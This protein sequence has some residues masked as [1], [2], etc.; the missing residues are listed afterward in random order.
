M[1]RF[2]LPE[3]W[4][5]YRSSRGG[6]YQVDTIHLRNVRQ[7]L[8][9]DNPRGWAAFPGGKFHGTICAPDKVPAEL[10]GHH[11]EL[12]ITISFRTAREAFAAIGIEV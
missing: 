11:F 10:C 9:C 2:K 1:A 4:R 3:G 8:P 5:H 6:Y 12:S 7:V